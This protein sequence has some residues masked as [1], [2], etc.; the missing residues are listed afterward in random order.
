[1]VCFRR[2]SY[3]STSCQVQRDIYRDGSHGSRHW[4]ARNHETDSSLG[5]ETCVIDCSH[6]IRG[7]G[8][9]EMYKSF[10]WLTHSLVECG[11]SL[12]GC[13]PFL[14]ETLTWR[15]SRSVAPTAPWILCQIQK[16]GLGGT[17]KTSI[18]LKRYDGYGQMRWHEGRYRT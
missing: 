6:Q 15:L 17:G 8:S 5:I 1:M 13:T 18:G 4:I 2:W 11:T 16:D 12:I 14:D 3:H 10:G 9:G 7:G